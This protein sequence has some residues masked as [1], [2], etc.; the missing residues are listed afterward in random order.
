MKKE[1]LF[2][3]GVALVVG[4]LVGILVSKGGK[5]TA[6]TQG[7]APSTP[8]VNVQQDIQLMEN[9]VANDPGNRGAWVQLGHAYFD[10]NQPVKA[11]EAYNKALEIDPNDSDVLTDQGVMFRRLGWFDRAEENF[12]KASELNPSHA[13]SLYNL[14]VVYRYDLQNPN[15]AREVWTRY[16]QINPSG[17]GADNIRRELESLDGASTLAPAK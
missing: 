5:S 2:F 7:T 11:I 13:Q 6:P 12:I 9:L 14:G 8:V 15:R 16:L 17:P 4:V 3:V 1:T 10:S